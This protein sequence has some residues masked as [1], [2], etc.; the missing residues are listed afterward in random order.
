V[1]VVTIAGTFTQRFQGS[2]P[3]L[4]E[5]LGKQADPRFGKFQRTYNLGDMSA[6]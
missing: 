2:S 4:G 6:G 1:G 5:K 3:A